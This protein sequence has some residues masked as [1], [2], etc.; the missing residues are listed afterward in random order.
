MQVLRQLRNTLILTLPE[1]FKVC[2]LYFLR[3]AVFFFLRHAQF[4]CRGRTL[5]SGCTSSGT[6]DR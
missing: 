4:V 2:V 6:E 3:S 5:T 1:P